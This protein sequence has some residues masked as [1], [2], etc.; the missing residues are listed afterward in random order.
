MA[1]SADHASKEVS[2]VFTDMEATDEVED[3]LIV[4][5]FRSPRWCHRYVVALP[6]EEEVGA[7]YNEDEQ[8]IQNIDPLANAVKMGVE[9]KR[10]GACDENVA[11]VPS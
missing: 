1:A 9:W 4:R 10:S 6:E 11:R 8:Y 2:L 5:K 3:V 7:A